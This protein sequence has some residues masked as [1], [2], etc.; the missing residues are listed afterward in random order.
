MELNWIDEALN[1]I[2][3]YALNVIGGILLLIGGW[4]VARW[5]CRGVYRGLEKTRIDPTL[6]KFTSKFIGWGVFVFAVVAALQQFGV[7]TTSFIAVLGAGGLAVGLAFQGTLSNFAAGVLLLIFRP[8]KVGDVV[9]IGGEA[10]KVFE[11]DLMVTKMD[12]TDN[13]RLI[14]P[15]S[16]IIGATIENSTHHPLRRV[17]VAVGTAY[18][19]DLERVRGVLEAALAG[20]KARVADP[21]PEVILKAFGASSID[22]ELRVWAGSSIAGQTAARQEVILATKRALDAAG[23]GIPFPQ[24]DV[25]L[26]RL[27]GVPEG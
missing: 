11:I 19:A 13:R 5:A 27:E 8:F 15:N 2:T 25:H 22:W 9:R 26:D 6:T 1:L 7:E 17:E 3:A 20:V 16:Q 21:S 14:I 10:G 12:T 18:G 23:L 4:V 24:M